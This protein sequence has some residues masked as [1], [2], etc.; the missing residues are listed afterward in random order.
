M[1]RKQSDTASYSWN[2]CSLRQLPYGDPLLRVD[3]LMPL[4]RTRQLRFQ[5]AASLSLEQTTHLTSAFL[6]GS[7]V[8]VSVIFFIP[9]CPRQG[10][11]KVFRSRQ[12]MG[13]SCSFFREVVKFSV[14]GSV[15]VFSLTLCCSQ[16]SHNLFLN[17]LQAKFPELSL[18]TP[19][20]P[21]L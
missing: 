1:F 4:C 19:F 8:C 15:C 6:Y 12:W 5:A 14:S 10:N 7:S 21:V 17:E 2:H 18:I 3:L 13:N 20:S 16:L 11:L 9:L